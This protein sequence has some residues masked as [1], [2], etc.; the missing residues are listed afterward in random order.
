[1]HAHR[2]SCLET[3]NPHGQTVPP[4]GFTTSPGTNPHSGQNDDGFYILGTNTGRD[5][6]FVLDRGS[7]RIFGPFPVGTRIKYT[8][9]PGRTPGQQKSGST[10]SQAGARPRHI[11]GP[12]AASV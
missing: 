10:N 8:Q 7:G 1:A 2:A 11:S 9:A 3:T 12:G 5:V 4:A 6:N